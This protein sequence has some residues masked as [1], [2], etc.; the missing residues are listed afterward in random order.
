MC[1]ISRAFAEYVASH[2][3][4]ARNRGSQAEGRHHEMLGLDMMMDDSGKLWLLEGNTDCGLDYYEDIVPGV[5]N[6]D[7]Q[8]ADDAII[9]HDLH[10]LLGIDRY[11]K[12]GDAAAW[13]CLCG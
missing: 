6:P 8:G 5:A 4:V 3:N 9:I 13:F 7:S 12:K 1:R 11:T 2:A 10:A